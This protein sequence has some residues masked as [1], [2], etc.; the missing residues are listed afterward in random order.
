ML[1]TY[2]FIYT[3]CRNCV[4]KGNPK[5]Y[6]DTKGSAYFIFVRRVHFNY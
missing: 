3:Y 1:C 6:T 5:K 4:N 2:D